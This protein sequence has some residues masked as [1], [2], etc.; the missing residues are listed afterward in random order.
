[1]PAGLD[2]HGML[3]WRAFCTADASGDG[4]LSRKEMF[5]ALEHE[6]ALQGRREE[7][8]EALKS[9]DSNENAFVEW[10]EFLELGRRHPELADMMHSATA[11]HKRGRRGRRR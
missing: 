3:L 6:G 7:W 1:M 10:D 9:V 11:G 2:A 5:D 8:T 4:R